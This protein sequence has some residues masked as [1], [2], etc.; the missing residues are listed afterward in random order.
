VERIDVSQN[1]QV[2]S[3]WPVEP[4]TYRKTDGDEAVMN[5]AFT[6]ADYMACDP[7][8]ERQFWHVD[9]AHWHDDMR[10]LSDYIEQGLAE[11]G[12]AIPYVVTVD[13]DGLL[14]RT[15]ITRNVVATVHS[16][17]SWWRSLQETGGVHNSFALRLLSE[18]KQRL[19]EAKQR[20]VEA[21]EQNYAAQLDQDIGALTK[22]IVQRIV[23]RLLAEEGLSGPAPSIPIARADTAGARAQAPVSTAAASAPVEAEEPEEEVA[24]F[25]DPYIDTP[26]CTSCNECTQLNPRLFAYNGNKQAYIKDASAGTFQDLVKAAELCPVKIIHPGKP[27]NP[28]EPGLGEWIERAARFN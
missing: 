7:R 12:S 11:T 9:R 4:V 25:D 8:F 10:S 24:T 23:G 22:E 6:P 20:E 14:G 27:K 17:R 5:L 13:P 21:I 18:E 26:L 1:S 16:A 2:E 15:V 3:D 19:L 28:D